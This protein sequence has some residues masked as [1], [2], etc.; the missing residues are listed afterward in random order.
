MLGISDNTPEDSGA[1]VVYT[2]PSKGGA[3][4]RISPR[5]RGPSYLHGWSPDGKWLTY[6][7]E[8]NDNFDVYKI[9]SKGGGDEI[10]LTSAPGLD[11]GAEYTRDGRHI[12]FNSA[13]TG[14]MQIW[15]MGPD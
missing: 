2:M 7:A 10:R 5:G 1:S 12:Y 11:D 9:S 13:R 8:R 15:R 6:I 14:R 3:A 4:K